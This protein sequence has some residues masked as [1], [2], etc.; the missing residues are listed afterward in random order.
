MNDSDF[1]FLG[2]W[3]PLADV[4]TSVG[5]W[6]RPTVRP[7][8]RKMVPENLA[9]LNDDL[10]PK[11]LGQ[12]YMGFWAACGRLGSGE[13]EEEQLHTCL[14][15]VQLGCPGILRYTIDGRWHTKCNISSMVGGFEHFFLSLV[16]TNDYKVGNGGDNW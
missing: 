1:T 10:F 16:L 3:H 4:G 2:A 11:W 7:T 14:G 13:G 6:H 5:T 12:F 9:H 8:G 15:S